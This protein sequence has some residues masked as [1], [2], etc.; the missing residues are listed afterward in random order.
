MDLPRAEVRTHGA[1]A[2]GV[3]LLRGWIRVVAWLRPRAAPL[4]I[5][6][7]ATLCMLAALD[8]VAGPIRAARARRV[9]VDTLPTIYLMTPAPRSTAPK[10]CT[11]YIPMTPSDALVFDGDPL[12]SAMPAPDTMP[13]T[14]TP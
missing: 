13:I 5:T 6:A 9:E 3:E 12:R 7:F 10:A 8:L 14:L 4:A 1:R 2:V 11:P